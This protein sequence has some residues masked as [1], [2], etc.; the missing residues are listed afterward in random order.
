MEKK[1]RAA[2][3]FLPNKSAPN[4][5]NNNNNN[6]YDDEEEVEEKAEKIG[7]NSLFDH[8]QLNISNFLRSPLQTK[9][10]QL[11]QM[12]SKFLQ[13]PFPCGIYASTQHVNEINA[14]GGVFKAISMSPQ[15]TIRQLNPAQLY[16][17]QAADPIVVG[18]RPP[19]SW[20][21]QQQGPAISKHCNNGGNETQKNQTTNF[22]DLADQE[23]L[24]E[25]RNLR[26]QQQRL[27][28]RS[29]VLEE[30]N[31]QLQL[32]LERLNHMVDKV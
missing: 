18:R 28:Q 9:F 25:A 6:N 5:H 14:G 21:Q 32:Q 24:N 12:N 19:P 30:Q 31:R 2:M 11:P 15:T 16:T 29:R 13:Q 4:L 27:E 20:Q 26:L 10:A 7:K 22:D 3:S 8:Q 23:V 17:L 1:R